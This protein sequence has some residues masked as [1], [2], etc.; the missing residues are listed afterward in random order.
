LTPK[1][2]SVLSLLAGSGGY[3]E[4]AKELKVELNTVRTHI[5]SLYEKLGVENR[6]E[7]VNLTRTLGLIRSTT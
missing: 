6:A 3:A 4:I 7:A 2:A 1:E 5:G